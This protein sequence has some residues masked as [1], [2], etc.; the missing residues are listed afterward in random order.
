MMMAS[1]SGDAAA[2]LPSWVEPQ[3]ATL[4]R[5]R[6]SDPEWL[7]ERKLDG[8]RCLAFCGPAGVTLK[9]R[10][11]HDITTT[12]PEIAAALATQ[13]RGDV[14][15]DGEV[16]GFDGAQTRFE[17]LQQRLG[18]ASP[19]PRL[20]EEIPVYYYPF[21]GPFAPGRGPRATPVT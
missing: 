14:V 20:L 1:E 6:F 5:E 11:K 8:E 12:F 18:L 9:S 16:V 19:P 4:T 13:R 3:L 10:S 15:E 21:D 17:R 2:A 7:Y